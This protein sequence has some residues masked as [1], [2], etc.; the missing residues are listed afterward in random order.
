MPAAHSSR[1]MRRTTARLLIL[2]AF[3]AALAVQSCSAFVIRH[4]DNNGKT[5]T[6]VTDTIFVGT[7]TLVDCVISPLYWAA[8]LFYFQPYVHTKG[9]SISYPAFFGSGC[10]G[11]G[12]NKGSGF[13]GT[14]TLNMPYFINTSG[15]VIVNFVD[16]NQKEVGLMGG[17]VEVTRVTDRINFKT[18]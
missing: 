7:G 6:Y 2:C 4:T 16:I 18:K 15:A 10:F 1:S 13:W 17:Q 11:R 8:G 14:L 3:F 12:F 5:K 9:G